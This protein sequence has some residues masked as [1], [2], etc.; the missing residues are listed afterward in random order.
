MR[1]SILLIFIGISLFS[2]KTI[3]LDDEQALANIPEDIELIKIPAGAY[4]SGERGVI[5]YVEYDYMMMK[6]PVTNLQYLEFLKA[7]DSLKLIV[8]D[9]LGVYGEY[10]G[11]QFWPPGYY[12]YIKFNSTYSRIGYYYPDVYFIKWRYVENRKEFY[13]NHPVTQ[14]TWFG[15]NAFAKFYG[16]RLPTA[17]EWEK[18]ARANSGNQY[19]WGDTLLLNNANYKDSGDVYDNDTT[20]VGFYNGDSDLFDS[21][22]PYGCYDMAG[23]V[24]EW[25]SSWWRDSSGKVI[26]GGSWNS[27]PNNSD[28]GSL[29]IYELMAWYEPAVGYLPENTSREI[30]FRCIK[31]ASY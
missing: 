3:T 22:S 18:A 29:L 30:G 28:S 10:K 6:Y 12:P 1:S 17:A 14:V 21:Y 24:W 25:T 27:S 23:N 15:A 31:D 4:S 7:A 19:P 16:M 11:D 20:P 2:C 26:K 8:I 13:S 5:K 9:S